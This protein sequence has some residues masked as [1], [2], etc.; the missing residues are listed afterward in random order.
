MGRA[1][2]SAACLVLLA[3]L[4]T[5][6]S[7]AEPDES[8]IAEWMAAQSES[9]EGRLGEMSSRTDPDDPPVAPGTGI[10]ITFEAPTAVAGV[11]LSCFGVDT[12]TFFVEVVQDVGTGVRTTGIEHR[13]ACGEGPFTAEVDSSE[14][15]AVR[16]DA[17]G[18]EHRGAW[19]AVVLD[20]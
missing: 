16:V 12:L 10:T 9:A 11:Q 14:A 20:D 8:E 2:A 6:C 3:A 7:S 17:Y 4:A 19:H 15:D 5:G 1:A 13:V 18:G